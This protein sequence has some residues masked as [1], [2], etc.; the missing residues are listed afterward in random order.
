MCIHNFRRLHHVCLL[1]TSI[2]QLDN[3][4]NDV[5]LYCI[6]NL[7][8]FMF[9]F[10]TTVQEKMLQVQQ[11]YSVSCSR[12]I[13]NGFF[14]KKVKH[15]NGPSFQKDITFSAAFLINCFA[16]RSHMA[17]TVMTQYISSY[18]N[19]P[20]SCP[21]SSPFSCVCRISLKYRIT[22]ANTSIAGSSLSL[23]SFKVVDSE[24]FYA[25]YK[26]HKKN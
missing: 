5:C 14:S 21:T 13:G 25:G 10:S 23:R 19:F 16:R 1:C 17:G 2:Q 26:K 6:T 9:W 15:S 3:L 20:S 12:T 24:R 22:A 8:I 18:L 11:T 7:I 4:G